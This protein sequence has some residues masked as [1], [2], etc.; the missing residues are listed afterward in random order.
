M[1]TIQ[2]FS[3]TQSCHLLPSSQSLFL[4]C[5][6]QYTRSAGNWILLNWVACLFLLRVIFLRLW[7]F[8]SFGSGIACIQLTTPS[9]IQLPLAL[10]SLQ[11]ISTFTHS[12]LPPLSIYLSLSLLGG[13]YVNRARTCILFSSNNET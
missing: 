10:F 11:H 2:I 3:F 4:F 13:L 1:I 7:A 8:S 9:F 5:P 12:S 6:L